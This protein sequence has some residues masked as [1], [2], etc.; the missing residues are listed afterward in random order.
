M[1]IDFKNIPIPICGLILS[2]FS[3]GNLLRRYD[4]YLRHVCFIF[5]LFL[6]IITTLKFILY[7]KILKEDLNNP[8]L[9]SVSGTYSMALMSFSVYFI[10]ISYSISLFI[11]LI[12]VIIHISIIIYFTTNF[13]FHK[14]NI[15]DVYASFFVVYVG[16]NNA[17]ITSNDLE[18]TNIG[19]IIFLY[20][21]IN[22]I[23]L[24]PLVLYR[25][26]NYN[27][28]EKNKP[29]I[30]VFNAA[31]HITIKGYLNTAKKYNKY[32]K[33]FYSI[34]CLFYIFS[35]YKVYDY[36]NI[37]FYPSFSAYTF[38]FVISAKATNGIYKRVL[39]NLLT[40]CILEF[41][42]IFSTFIVF[43]IF[44]LYIKHIFNTNN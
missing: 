41:Q 25:Y 39:N 31:V 1:L 10:N 14:F 23:F 38:P 35:L 19:Y 28:D 37:K 29:I 2:F 32:I 27:I 34:C 43:Y 26:I 30:L 21:F 11:W 12:G 18:I 16:I 3:L 4:P 40:K 33:V 7:P 22:L 9:A 42:L 5:G 36:K 8:I 13:F 20:G 17:A 15:K 24:L 44:F 6:L